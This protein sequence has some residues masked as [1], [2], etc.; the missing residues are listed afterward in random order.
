MQ[1]AVMK[2]AGSHH[3]LSNL[4]LINTFHECYVNALLQLIHIIYFVFASVT[5]TRK[6]AAQLLAKKVPHIYVLHMYVH[7]G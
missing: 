1:K 6:F 3:D 2:I 4:Y 5:I 7:A